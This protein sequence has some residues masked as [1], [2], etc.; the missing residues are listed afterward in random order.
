MRSDGIVPD[1][2][3]YST[4][5]KAAVA[6]GDLTRAE[7]LVS[8]MRKAG[9]QPDVVVL[10][11]VLAGYAAQLRWDRAVEILAD[12]E[13]AGIRADM[14]SFSLLLRACVRAQVPDQARQALVM[15]RAAD[16]QPNTRIY[17]MLLSAY[18]QA[19]RLQESLALLQ[20]MQEEQ[21]RANKY[22]YSALMEA[23]IV[24]GQPEM[25]LP[26]FEQMKAEGI[27]ADTVTYTLLIRSFV[28]QA[29]QG[30]SD[31]RRARGVRRT[32][33]GGAREGDPLVRNV[34]AVGAHGVTDESIR[35]AGADGMKGNAMEN[36]GMEGGDMG[37]GGDMLGRAFETVK[38]MSSLQ[39]SCAPNVITFNALLQGCKEASSPAKVLQAVRSMLALGIAPNR[40][41]FRI[42]ASELPTASETRSDNLS[43]HLLA[44]V[45]EVF[46]EFGRQLNGDV[47]LALLR[48]CAAESNTELVLRMR[49]KR[50]AQ[51]EAVRGERA[52][53]VLRQVQMPEAIELENDILERS[54]A[55][56]I[57]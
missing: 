5:I 39:G 27:P 11:T 34:Q 16:L 25:A 12:F 51:Q 23:C 7:E 22:S 43:L 37:E 45:T 21:T 41:T 2:V 40:N 17:S 20:E 57:R 4:V 44:G 53:F 1:V 48:A 47:Y 28:A 10:N 35:M 29:T 36:D 18:A 6:T 19:G 50:C 56:R 30:V 49:E 3:S 24:A 54:V 55:N 33:K 46:D 26:L 32:H 15:M 9:V 52:T 13:E 14:L 42:L 31:R 38:E 8:E